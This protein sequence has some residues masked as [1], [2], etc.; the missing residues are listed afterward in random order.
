MTY[1]TFIS[2]YIYITNYTQRKSALQP[3][4]LAVDRQADLRSKKIN[5]A[6]DI[7]ILKVTFNAKWKSLIL[8][9]STDLRN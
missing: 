1:C 8:P 2:I 3:I 6:F 7:A 5:I 4:E 9:L